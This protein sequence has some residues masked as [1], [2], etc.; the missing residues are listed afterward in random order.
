MQ[1]FLNVQKLPEW[2][3]KMKPLCLTRGLYVFSSTVNKYPLQSALSEPI[4]LW[5]FS[6]IIADHK[7]K[8]GDNDY[9][10]YFFFF[11]FTGLQ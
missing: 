4:T 1:H 6:K 2:R 8:K 5:Y 11:Y 3:C 10:H 7:V 9:L